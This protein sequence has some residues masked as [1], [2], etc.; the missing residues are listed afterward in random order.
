SVMRQNATGAKPR[1]S[2][3]DRF[4]RR[5]ELDRGEA[6]RRSGLPQRADHDEGIGIA[7]GAAKEAA[8][9]GAGRS[10]TSTLD[11]IVHH[12]ASIV[13][14]A[15]GRQGS[16]TL[17]ISGDVAAVARSCLSMILSENRYPLF[18]IML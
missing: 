13:S 11:D 17:R 6:E 15:I 14:L 8:V 12:L 9:T 18:R 3:G 4:Q 7:P 1:Q 10:E 5:E 2:R 16:R